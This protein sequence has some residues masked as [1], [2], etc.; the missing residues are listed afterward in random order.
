MMARS[1][2]WGSGRTG[3]LGEATLKPREALH[4]SPSFEGSELLS[5]LA[6]EALSQSQADVSLSFEGC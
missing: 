4:L 2:E 6:E 5:A 3:A 1:G